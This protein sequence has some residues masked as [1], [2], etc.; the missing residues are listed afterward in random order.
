MPPKD[1]ILFSSNWDEFFEGVSALE[2]RKEK[3]DVF[4]RFI[5]LYSMNGSK[6]HLLFKKV[7]EGLR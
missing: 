1:L 3:G 4:E 5:K 6:Y 2:H 7:L